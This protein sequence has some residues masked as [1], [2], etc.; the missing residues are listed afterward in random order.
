MGILDRVF[1]RPD[2][3]A[4]QMRFETFIRQNA[5]AVAQEL[6]ILGPVVALLWLVRVKAL[7]RLPSELT[8]GDHAA[9]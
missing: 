8:G 3:G 9:Q 5:R 6:L 7:A 1:R 4:S 2:A